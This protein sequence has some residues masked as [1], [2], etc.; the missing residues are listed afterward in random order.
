MHGQPISASPRA[1]CKQWGQTPRKEEGALPSP[2]QPLH[3]CHQAHKL[4][5]PYDFQVRPIPGQDPHRL[6]GTQPIPRGPGR[7]WERV[8]AGDW[9]PEFMLDCAKRPGRSVLPLSTEPGLAGL[10]GRFQPFR[11]EPVLLGHSRPAGRSVWPW[12]GR[13][14]SRYLQLMYPGPLSRRAQL[15]H[16]VLP[17]LL[18]QHV[19]DSR[20]PSG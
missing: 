10:W 9:W 18:H 5:C 16:L 3:R 13:Q 17:R 7:G 6:T 4:T 2:Y 1:L 12:K 8:T 19:K 20:R 11:S 15:A 14:D